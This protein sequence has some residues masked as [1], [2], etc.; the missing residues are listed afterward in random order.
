MADSLPRT[1]ANT[2]VPTAPK[3]PKALSQDAQDALAALLA[4]DDAEA[5][6]LIRMAL[7]SKP[8]REAFIDDYV[9]IPAGVQVGERGQAALFLAE[10][11]NAPTACL[12]AVTRPEPNTGE[13][14]LLVGERK[15]GTK[16]I[17]GGHFS[18]FT[19][20][21][22]WDYFFTKG[23]SVKEL[24]SIFRNTPPPSNPQEDTQSRD[25][26]LMMAVTKEMVQE[27]NIFLM[28]KQLSDAEKQV[29]AAKV[30]QRFPD[31][32]ISY[33]YDVLDKNTLVSGVGDIG[34]GWHSLIIGYGIVI[35]DLPHLNQPIAGDD[36]A[37]TYWVNQRDLTSLKSADETRP[38]K[39]SV[40]DMQYGEKQIIEN[41]FT[42]INR[43]IPL[44]VKSKIGENLPS[45]TL[46]GV[47]RRVAR[48]AAHFG[49]K[50]SDLLG[51][52]PRPFV[53]EE[54][55][56][57]V[58][59]AQSFHRNY[60]EAVA[61]KAKGAVAMTD[62]LELFAAER[63]LLFS[64]ARENGLGKDFVQKVDAVSVQE[65]ETSLIRSQAKA[66]VAHGH[67]DRIAQEREAPQKRA[68]SR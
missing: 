2:R 36:I 66:P 39:V 48:V 47:E 19:A 54:A 55:A 29:L 33:D 53:G 3:D 23:F 13:W 16:T 45:T 18:P 51:V 28:P 61:S 15:N 44:V 63:D 1:I 67:A 64:F 32:S 30:Q 27:S 57:Y 24:H 5:A 6:D 65:F 17:I 41:A 56:N 43:E 42:A 50:S 49:V 40:G 68:A 52:K 14:Q 59:R 46:H 60:L 10:Y 8:V 58:G 34:K 9:T 35:N 22:C 38:G 12:M 11:F 4:L 26:D 21:E 20:Q 25:V 31:V 62:V 37:K 7:E